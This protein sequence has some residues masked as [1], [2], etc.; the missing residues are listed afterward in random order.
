VVLQARLSDTENRALGVSARPR[1]ASWARTS[2]PDLR[3]DEREER[4][5][6]AG[7]QG[8]PTCALPRRRGGRCAS[9]RSVAAGPT[10]VDAL[11]ATPETM[12]LGLSREIGTLP[13]VAFKVQHGRSAMLHR[14]LRVTILPLIMADLP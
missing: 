14:K 9:Q 12:P 13:E 1:V 8:C 5:A 6:V 3:G 7:R 10:G 4:D 11:Q 2:M